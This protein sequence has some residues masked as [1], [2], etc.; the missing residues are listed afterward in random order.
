MSHAPLHPGAKRS[1]FRPAFVVSSMAWLVLPLAGC[2]QQ[3]EPAGSLAADIAAAGS[4]DTAVPMP[5]TAGQVPDTAGPVPDTAG[6]APG[7]A[8]AV[9]PVWAGPALDSLRAVLDSLEQRIATAGEAEL[10][11]L[12]LQLGRAKSV[13]VPLRADSHAAYARARPAEFAYDEPGGSWVYTG[14]AFREL[15]RRFP[16]S[17]LV[18]DAAYA[19]TLLPLRGECEGF[20]SGCIAWEWESITEFLRNHPESPLADSAVER[21]LTI[22][23]MVEPDMELRVSTWHLDPVKLR[24]LVERLDSI[25]RV[26]PSARGSRLLGRAGELWAQ[27]VE[28]DRAAAAYRAALDGADGHARAGLEAQLA[29]LPARWFVLEPAR[30]VHTGLVELHWQPVDGDVRSILVNRSGEAA[31]ADTVVARLGPEA[32]SWVDTGTHPATTY[33]YQVMVETGDGMVPSNPIHAMTPTSRL[34]VKG[35]AVS[36]TDRM[37]HVFGLLS[38]GFPVVLRI[39]P[40]GSAFE[41][42]NGLFIGLDDGIHRPVYDDHLEEIWLPDRN[43]R[44][45]LR[46]AGSLED[47]PA[48]LLAAVRTG[49]DQLHEYHQATRGA[50]RL[51]VNV[52]EAESTAWIHPGNVAFRSAV[53]CL[54]VLDFC[55]AAGRNEIVRQDTAGTILLRVPFASPDPPDLHYV[56]GIHADPLDGSAWVVLGRIGHLV[57]VDTAGNV[58]HDMRLAGEQETW[59]LNV[60]S[61]FDH[62][63][64]WFARIR[65]SADRSSTT[66]ELVRLDLDGPELPQ[67]VVASYP[68][69]ARIAPDLQGGVWLVT[70]NQVIH[71][72]RE[73]RTL[74][75]GMLDQG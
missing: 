29:A 74:F 61:D 5:D 35:I 15:I 19:I 31:G 54:A 25:G 48:D 49:H 8:A 16:H 50:V 66:R 34:F 57:N 58:R 6:P 7:A 41:R 53:D 36:T 60:A 71:V 69:G 14:E 1:L 42:L 75:T 2:G 68:I 63:A 70:W 73:G 20:V 10:P 59:S 27:F 51:L 24:E 43:G 52:D 11:A 40:G 47:P 3:Q 72:D 22:F 39:A 28:Y 45:V 44:G 9:M 46:F 13:F 67:Q 18:E 26:L 56:T 64:I 62:R 17:E 55:W 12:L 30:V 65:L 38:N 4:A 33:R 21:T 32:R 23:G 37:L